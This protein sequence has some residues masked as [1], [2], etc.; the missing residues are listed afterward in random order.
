MIYRWS[1][2]RKSAIA[3]RSTT[4]KCSR[5]DIRRYYAPSK[6]AT[7]PTRSRATSSKRCS[8]TA[9]KFAALWDEHEVGLAAE[10]RKRIAH[11]AIGVIEL[12]CL[13]LTAENQTEKLVV[14]TATLGSE[15]AQRLAPPQGRRRPELPTLDEVRVKFAQP[16]TDD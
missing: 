1:P 10:M 9:L 4:T 16:G 7:R 8:T 15:D 14:F 3:S 6:A 11:P 12:D 2:T 5:A 13:I